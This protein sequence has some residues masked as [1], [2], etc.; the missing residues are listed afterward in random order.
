MSVSFKIIGPTTSPTQ[1]FSRI[2]NFL[3]TCPGGSASQNVEQLRH[4]A[5]VLCGG[6]TPM[7]PGLGYRQQQKDFKAPS[8]VNTID[9]RDY[10]GHAVLPLIPQIYQPNRT[11][12]VNS[13]E[14][15]D[16]FSIPSQQHIGKLEASE[17]I[18]KFLAMLR[19]NGMDVLFP[20]THMDKVNL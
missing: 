17:P 19:K 9:S 13:A 8:E 20:I 7:P 12:Q 3:V 15:N 4:D 2:I 6:S 11:A 10:H 18:C 14:V 16:L 5:T 1:F